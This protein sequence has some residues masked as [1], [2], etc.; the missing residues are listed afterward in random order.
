[1]NNLPAVP[2]SGWTDDVG[3]APRSTLRT[4]PKAPRYPMEAA[5]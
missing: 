2:M 1:M 5:R 4:M 3:Y